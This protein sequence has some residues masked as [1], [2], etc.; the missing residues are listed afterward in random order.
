MNPGL[1]GIDARWS[2]YGAYLQRVIDAVQFQWERHIITSVSPPPASGSSVSVKFVMN[3]EGK[4]TEIK[5]VEQSNG[6]NEV[7]ARACVS[8]IMARSP[9][10]PW[11]EDMQAVLGTQQPMTFTFYYQ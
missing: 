10:G 9:Y 7:A 3:H 5:H 2:N 8:A 4:I 11:T 1:N 6:A